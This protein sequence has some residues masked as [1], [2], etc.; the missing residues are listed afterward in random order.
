MRRRATDKPTIT[1]DSGLFWT[2]TFRATGKRTKAQILKL[3]AWI[4]GALG[5]GAGVGSQL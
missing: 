4:L 5:I 3:L 2:I 1:G